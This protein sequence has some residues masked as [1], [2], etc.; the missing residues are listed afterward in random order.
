MAADS[1]SKPQRLISLYKDPR[2]RLPNQL[3]KKCLLRKFFKD[4]EFLK[5]PE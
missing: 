2:L 1:E 4:S 5:E 3:P